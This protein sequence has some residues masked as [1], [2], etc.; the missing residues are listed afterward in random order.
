MS[1]E[2]PRQY[3]EKE[4]RLILKSA[5]E[6]QQQLADRTVGSSGGMSLA[7]L[8]QVAVEAGVDP[9]FV[10]QAAGRLD[11][12]ASPSDRNAFLG[13]P[14]HIIVE[15]TVNVASDAARFED[16]LATVRAM[17]HEV[18][19]V[20]TVGRQFGWKGRM[21]GAKT[22]VSVSAGDQRTTIRVRVE[23]DEIALGHFMLKGMFFGVGGGLVGSAAAS[24]LLGP[25]GVLVGAGTLA[26]GYLWSRRGFRG[27][28]AR[29][30]ARAH[31]LVD[32]LAQRASATAIGREGG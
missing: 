6:L 15:R 12:A 7:E 29:Y 17:T 23:L 13:R 18:G 25:L 1:T 32:A 28:A 20:S 11:A 16:F 14:T 26:T 4:V 31:D 21:D 19:Q 24:T 30:E 8:E 27:G 2:P 10:R 22:E 3:T 5:V 9:T